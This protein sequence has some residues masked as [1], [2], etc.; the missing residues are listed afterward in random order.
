MTPSETVNNRDVI[1]VQGLAYQIRG[2]ERAPCFPQK[3]TD[4][5]KL[6][7]F[8]NVRDVETFITCTP[9]TQNFR[10]MCVKLEPVP[11]KKYEVLAEPRLR[12]TGRTC[13]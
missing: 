7:W 1:F 2:T 3:H 12:A 9:L 6:R 8:D 4:V 13:G 11:V 10:S 5:P